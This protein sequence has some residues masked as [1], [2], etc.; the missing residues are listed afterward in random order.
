MSESVRGSVLVTGGQVIATADQPPFAGWVSWSDGVITA[1]G[2]GAPSADVVAAHREVVDARGCVVTPGFVN[3]HTHLFQTMLRGIRTD[4]CLEDW[5]D[6]TIWPVIGRFTPEDFYVAAL[7]GSV[8]NLRSG[9]TTVFE[10]H[11]VHTSPENSH[12]VAAALA[13]SGI[14]GT[15]FHGGTDRGE[16]LATIV[17]G[18]AVDSMVTTSAK[19]V[20]EV[21]ELAAAWHGHDG[22]R[23]SVGVAAQTAW[24]C[25][26]DFCEDIAVYAG[27]NGLNAHAHCAETERSVQGCL[28]DVGMREVEM[29]ERSGLLRPGTS[30]A[31]CVWLDEREIA[32]LAES[33]AAVSHCPVSNAY[34]GAG[35]API[36][37]LL[38][39]GARVALAT[40]GPASNNRQDSFESL[41]W[42]VNIQKAKHADAAVLTDVQALEMAWAGGAAAIAQPGLL[43]VLRPGAHADVVITRIDSNFVAPVHDLVATLVFGS[44]P[45]DVRDVFVAGRGV[46]RDGV[47]TTVDEA[48]LRERASTRA[49]ELGL[50]S[51]RVSA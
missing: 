25:T 26:P 5:L 24:L 28:D 38:R 18:Q 12:R 46:V 39:S 45:A 49:R 14:R 42:A 16:A 1:V 27:A 23:I 17:G 7:L 8:E 13:D 10:N 21:D 32:I 6:I 19:Y 11:Y 4:L 37:D 35:I 2:E 33:G 41:K 9:A 31:H 34:L 40:D 15:L 36:P 22:G 43:G 47:C 48:A 50:R 44:M 20:N 3:A 51:L 30:L 29:F